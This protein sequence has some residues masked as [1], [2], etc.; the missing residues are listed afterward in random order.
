ML[1]LSRP[2]SNLAWTTA[3]HFPAGVGAFP[4]HSKS[5]A[6]ADQWQSLRNQLPRRDSGYF[7]SV[8]LSRQFEY[9]FPVSMTLIDLMSAMPE[10][11]LIHAEDRKHQAST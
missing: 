7:G 1:G 2:Q 6:P 11:C 10:L 5:V 9:Q 8:L 3:L 4:G